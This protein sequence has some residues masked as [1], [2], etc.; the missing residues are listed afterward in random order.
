MTQDDDMLQKVE[1]YRRLVLLYEKLHAEINALISRY[2]GSSENMPP[3][4]LAHYRDLARNRDETLNDMRWLEQ[5]LLDED[6]E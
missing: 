1:D 5:Q 6:P 2:G 4:E 3:D